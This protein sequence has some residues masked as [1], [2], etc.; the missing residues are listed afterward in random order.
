VRVTVVGGGLAGCEVA[1]QLARRGVPVTLF[2]MKPG[3]RT[4]AQKSDELAE[5]VCS[6]SLRSASLANAVG[7][8]KEEMRRLGSAIIAAADAHRV[9]AGDAL[10][11]D[12]DGFARAVGDAVRAQA[13]IELRREEVVDLPAARPLVIATG[14]LTSDPLAERL[15]ALTGSA[16]LYFYDSIAPI[17]DGETIDWS[18]V[19][20]ASRY[21]KGDDYVNCPLTEAQYRAFVGEVRRAQKVPLHMF[22]EPRYF[23]ACLP[24][25]VL[26][27]RGDDALAFGPM[28][29]VGLVDPRTGRRP[30][31]VVQLRLENRQGTAYNLVGFQ[32][33]LTYP[34]QRRIFRTIPGLERAELLRLGSVHRNTYLDS[35]RLL[36]E[37]LMLRSAHGVHFAG[38]VTGVEGYVESAAVGLYV[39]LLLA[40][41]GR[42]ARVE[43]PPRTTALGALLAHVREGSLS[44]RF[45]PQNVNWGLFPRLEG[46]RRKDKLAWSERALADLA[47]WADEHAALGSRA[48]GAAPVAALTG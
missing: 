12:R 23:E 47:A 30:F 4:P 41:E 11:V 21:G 8:L 36:D 17:V 29:P 39:G 33:K 44:G 27:E 18:R 38:Q 24:I 28:K 13:R 16:E 9:P 19:F 10:A 15:R 42:G 20:R 35:P 25:E 3:R 46:P 6:N 48:S 37:R 5:L 26:A 43:P 32:T 1:L 40:A 45:T 14:P 31:A 34:E 7:L 22:E 2:E